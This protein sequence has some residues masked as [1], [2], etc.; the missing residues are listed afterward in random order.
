MADT[1][2][3]EDPTI[4]QP[5]CAECG[6]GI[7]SQSFELIEPHHSFEQKTKGG[8]VRGGA[9]G[10]PQ[11]R[12]FVNLGSSGWM[13]DDPRASGPTAHEIGDHRVA[14]QAFGPRHTHE[15]DYERQHRNWRMQQMEARG[16]LG[17]QF[18]GES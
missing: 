18:T 3:I 13:H 2:D 12:P 9:V 6:L 5:H 4:R 11:P 8:L 17:R 15:T 1:D 7:R 10:L 16:T 14:P